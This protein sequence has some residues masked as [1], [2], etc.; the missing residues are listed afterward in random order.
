MKYRKSQL[1]S[2][3]SYLW[4][5][6]SFV[7]TLLQVFR[8]V[9]VKLA[10]LRILTFENITFH[11]IDF[12]NLFNFFNFFF[13]FSRDKFSRMWL[14]MNFRHLT[15]FCV[16]LFSA[17]RDILMISPGFIFA[18]AKCVFMIFVEIKEI[19]LNS[20]SWNRSINIVL[21]SCYHNITLITISHL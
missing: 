1:R 18:I 13:N 21:L 16:D 15:F 12:F 17:D 20:R 3:V 2:L 6:I 8:F 5:Q 10:T 19:I 11:G 9:S 7:A 14:W 4:R